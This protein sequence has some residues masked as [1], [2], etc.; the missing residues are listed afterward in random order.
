M[1]FSPKKYQS[2]EAIMEASIME[3][4]SDTVIDGKDVFGYVGDEVFFAEYV[5]DEVSG[6]I[7]ACAMPNE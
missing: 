1:L 6:A 3:A 7:Y 5:Y 2:V 4:H